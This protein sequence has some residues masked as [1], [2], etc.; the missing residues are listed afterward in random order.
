MPRLSSSYRALLYLY[1]RRREVTDDHAGEGVTQLGISEGLGIPR[2]HITR[3]VRPLVEDGLLVEEKRH[4]VDKDRK[5]NV[6]SLTSKGLAKIKELIDETSDLEVTVRARGRTERM[7]VSELLETPNISLLDL[8]DSARDG[9]TLELGGGRFI[10]CDGELRANP[11]LDREEELII[12]EEFLEDKASTLVVL[13][14][15]GYGSSSL[16]KKIALEMTDKPL[17]WH[18]LSNDGSRTRIEREVSAFVKTISD[19]ELVELNDVGA[20]LC[21]DNYHLIPEDGVDAMMD[22]MRRLSGG[23]TKLMVAMRRDNPSYNRFYQKED[24]DAGRVVEVYLGRL[25]YECVEDMFGSDM[26]PEALKLIY[27][28]TRGQ[29]LALDLLKK[30]DDEGLRSMYPNEEVR[31]MMYLRTKKRERLYD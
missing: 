28:M 12:A 15:R 1:D 7:G 20:I 24:V 22:L 14:N 13:S 29:P 2:S 16:M 23:C 27:M 8:I 3:V 19:E 30:G 4:V 5:L 9:K 17:L 26:D 10:V 11:V 21:F 6:Y 31:F 18:D 25:G